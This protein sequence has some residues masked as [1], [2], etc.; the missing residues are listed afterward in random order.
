MSHGLSDLFFRACVR[1]FTS[2]N[3]RVPW[4]R[5]RRKRCFDSACKVPPWFQAWLA[6]MCSMMHVLQRS[7]TVLLHAN[8]TFFSFSFCYFLKCK[9]LFTWQ[10]HGFSF[11]RA[12]NSNNTNILCF[13]FSAIWKFQAVLYLFLTAWFTDLCLWESHSDLVY[14]AMQP[15]VR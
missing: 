12:D 8:F 5:K 4:R 6:G 1:S 10:V 13:Y 7:Y 11:C 9:E 3:L 2:L 14:P 15:P